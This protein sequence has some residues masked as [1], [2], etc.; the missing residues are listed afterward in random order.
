MKRLEFVCDRKSYV[1][2]LR[3]LG[4]DITLL[5]AQVPDEVKT[6]DSRQ[7]TDED[8]EQIFDQFR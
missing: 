6:D 1:V 8:L 2:L 7:G 4:C 3:G 5:N